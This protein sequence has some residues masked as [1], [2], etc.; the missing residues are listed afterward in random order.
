MRWFW[1]DRF[2]E[3]VSGKYAVSTKNVSLAEEQIDNYCPGY[4]YM[5]ASLII[6][7][8]AQTGGLLVGQLND[9]ADRIVLAKIR[10]SQFKFEVEPGDTLTYRSEIVSK[11]DG[12]AVVNCTAY[13]GDRLLVEAELMFANLVDKRFDGVELFEPAGFCRMLRMMKLFSVGVNEDGTPINIP[14]HMLEAE[15]AILTQ[16]HA[17]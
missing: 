12:G 3:F 6:E 5:P 10:Q 4:P 2:E 8:L 13:V 11:S 17:D 16:P 15:K 1:V 9:F 7:G 14:P